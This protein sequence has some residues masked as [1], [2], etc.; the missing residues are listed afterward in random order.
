MLRKSILPLLVPLLVLVAANVNGADLYLAPEVPASPI[1]AEA[2]AGTQTAPRVAA[3]GKDYL[4]IW[5]D[6]RQYPWGTAALYGTR[7]CAD[8]E[9]AERMGHFIAPA[10]YGVLACD[11]TSCLIAGWRYT[12]DG[13]AP[14]VQPIDR[15]AQPIGAAQPL[16]GKAPREIASNGSS[17]LLV[18]E[19][20]DFTMRVTLLDAAGR[21]VQSVVA[22]MWVAKNGITVRN[23]GYIIL[24][25]DTTPCQPFTRCKASI[26][27]MNV[28]SQGTITSQRVIGPTGVVA[29]RV[30][31]SGFTE[32][33]MLAAWSRD[34]STSDP[35]TAGFVLFDYDGNMIGGQHVLPQI[36]SGYPDEFFSVASA[37]GDFLLTF[38]VDNDFSVGAMR[39]RSDGTLIDNEPFVFARGPAY[40]PAAASHPDS[41][42]LIWPE[43]RYATLDIFSHVVTNFEDLAANA[44]IGRVTTETAPA[45]MDMD[46][47]AEHGERF[48]VW[49]ET[50]QA[51]RLVVSIG[52]VPLTIASV[53]SPALFRPIA[54]RGASSYLV[55]WPDI[56]SGTLM[57]ARVALDGKSVQGEPFIVDPG[58]PFG[59]VG[60]YALC[61][62]AWNGGQFLVVWSAGVVKGRRFDES[63]RPLDDAPVDILT[64]QGAWNGWESLYAPAVTASSEGFVVSAAGYVASILDPGMAGP[65]PSRIWTAVVGRDAHV[66]ALS[67]PIVDEQSFSFDVGLVSV[68]WAGDRATILWNDTKFENDSFARCISA[69][70]ISPSGTVVAPSRRLH[71]SSNEGRLLPFSSVGDVAWNGSEHVVVW[72]EA[73]GETIGSFAMRFDRELRPLDDAPIRI[74]PD[75]IGAFPIRVSRSPEGVV[76]ARA[77][78]DPAAGDVPRIFTRSAARSLNSPRRRATYH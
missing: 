25:W 34:M 17:F 68:T 60:P 33:R 26:A 55:V 74:S 66:S 49:T 27:L 36:V 7:I 20:T 75:T 40:A 31:A 76:I 59:N 67:G 78:G 53:E 28:D 12:P 54:A 21:S 56:A 19:E 8:G 64:P 45:Q 70:Q 63:G 77:H 73:A 43:Q 72:N 30:L 1:T 44:T 5:N 37:H 4:A 50:G 15:D 39:V 32:D 22:P 11:G 51:R 16:A 62:V 47:V 65:P 18:S 10:S 69:I 24:G 58:L 41:T 14:F 9:P 42:L 46:V 29:G 71:C 61:D 3:N 13:A 48:V 52:G 38:R 23:G 35:T 2:A 57:A 6:D